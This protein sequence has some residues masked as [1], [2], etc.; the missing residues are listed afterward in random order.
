MRNSSSIIIP[1]RL[2][3]PFKSP[4]TAFAG[5]LQITLI[6]RIAAWEKTRALALTA[7]GEMDIREIA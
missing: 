1:T 3:V 2:Q 4:Y 5:Y 6:R 7:K